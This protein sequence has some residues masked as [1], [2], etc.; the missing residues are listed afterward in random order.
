MS[1]FF[2]VFPGQGSQHPG[3][4]KS[5][6]ENFS[7]AREVFEE[8]SETLKLDL[9]KLCF[10]GSEA[11]LKLTENTQPC[12]LT[13]SVASYRT[14][15]KE[16][17]F[18]PAIAAGHSLGEYSALV[19][20]GALPL[21]H[22]VQWVRSRGQAMQRAVPTGEGAMAAILGLEDEKVELL[23]T[24]ATDQAKKARTP[25]SFSVAATVEAVNYNA[26]GQLVIAGSKD[27]VDAAIALLADPD[28]KGGKS[29]PLP[30]SAP[31][32]SS[33]MKPARDEMNKIFK[34]SS[35]K[36]SKPSCAYVPNRTARATLEPGVV[37]DLL[38]EQVDHAVLWKQSMTHILRETSFGLEIGTGKVLQGLAKRISKDSGVSAEVHTVGDADSM[39]AAEAFLKKV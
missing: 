27:G 35:V 14:L 30:V 6:F 1:K 8:A 37:F 7:S 11:D 38:V 23:C 36:P 13:V 15:Q 9:K 31:F 5:L 3:M 22:A 24:R 33:L 29:I 12:L 32:H 2:A 26:P 17:G 39:K 16:F 18:S 19:S 4:G 21:G 10:E 25:G 20:I 28:F 34:T